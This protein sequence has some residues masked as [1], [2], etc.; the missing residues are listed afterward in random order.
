MATTMVTSI[1][2]GDKVNI[3]HV[4]DSRA[5]LIRAGKIRRLTSDHS[6]TSFQVK[7]GLLLERNA[8]TES[9]H[10]STLT[11]G[12]WDSTPSAVMTC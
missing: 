9:A 4:G 8:M 7:L 1:F 10:R 12:H 3:A 11:R 6:Y 2:R 5:Y